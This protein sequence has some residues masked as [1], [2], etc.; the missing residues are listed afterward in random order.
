[1]N[2]SLNN[3]SKWAVLFSLCPAV[4]L[5]LYKFGVRI[6]NPT[7]IGFIFRMGGDLSI[8]Y[9]AWAFLRE[10]PWSFP[11]GKLAGY[12]SPIGTYALVVNADQLLPI[13]L[14]LL[15]P[16][17]PPDF[18]Y[19]GWWFLSCY[20]LQ[21]YFGYRLMKL[22]T[23]D[24]ILQ[25]LGVCFFLLSPPLL[26]RSI[27][28][29]DGP[30]AQWV[31]LAAFTIYFE[32]YS[33]IKNIN[34]I[35]FWSLLI[36]AAFPI[37]TYLCPMVV[38]L[39]LAFS[40][41]HMIFTPSYRLKLIG[42]VA[43]YP[44]LVLASFASFGFFNSGISYQFD[45]VS[46]NTYS[47]NL[48][49][50]INP[51]QWSAFI[52]ALP[53]RLGQAEGFNYMGLGLIILIA[54]NII[55]IV[56]WRPRFNNLKYL[57]PFL[58]TILL[59]FIYAVSNRITWG[60]MVL[61]RYPLPELF[62]RMVNILRCS[63]RFGWPVFYAILYGT[64]F[65]IVSM[66]RKSLSILVMSSC[67]LIQ[68]ADLHKLLYDPVFH[69]AGPVA[70]PLKSPAWQSIGQNFNKIIIYPPFIYAI[71]NEDDSKYFLL[72]AYKHHLS[73]DTGAPGRLPV[74]RMQIYKEELQSSLRNGKLDPKGIYLFADPIDAETLNLFH[75]WDHCALVDEYI[76]YT[77]D[78]RFL[79]DSNRLEV[80]PLTF[81]EFL[82]K[83]EGNTILIA[84]REYLA[85][86]LMPEGVKKYLLE[87]GSKLP[88]LGFAGSY[89]GVF[90]RGE[91]VVEKISNKSA[92]KV[93]LRGEVAPSGGQVIAD[94]DIELYS[95][96]VPFGNKASIKIAGV[97]HS[98]GRGGLNIVAIDGD[99]NILAS[100]FFG[101]NNPNRTTLCYTNKARD[102][103]NIDKLTK[104]YN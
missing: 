62:L 89:V 33:S 77:T 100:T 43:L 59:F 20:C 74:E 98:R 36:V 81:R 10:S 27:Q 58:I 30:C 4:C 75:K 91:K 37:F 93:E 39:A 92:V 67:L 69:T 7:N 96:G 45:L 101:V 102:L 48:N 31:L 17:L 34:V 12:F 52:P 103:Q 40:F 51:F 79:D 71:T 104:N 76:V 35:L 53:Y 99:G 28:G 26:V 97:E 49:S 57:I 14:K 87:K 64:L 88:A 21:A 25:V 90:S 23:S 86:A 83:Y 70:S 72:Y 38:A 46:Y 47:L 15:S 29:H 22:I 24:I 84:A 80:E 2:E 95:A 19:F 16:F 5:F 11:V 82:K 85:P 8:S 9:L 50:F 55:Y 73:I 66:N 42:S 54:Y 78:G 6:L 94:K 1:M 65:C 61:F 18:Q 56:V 60:N 3:S 13:P 63:G 32:N 41:G 44:L 68:V